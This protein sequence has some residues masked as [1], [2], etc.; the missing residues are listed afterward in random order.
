MHSELLPLRYD[1]DFFFFFLTFFALLLQPFL[2]GKG[3]VITCITFNFILKAEHSYNHVLA[4]W[5][6]GN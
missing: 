4:S 1:V 3:P 5:L 2:H 6:E